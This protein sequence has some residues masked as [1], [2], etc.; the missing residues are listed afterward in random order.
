MSGAVKGNMTPC[1]VCGSTRFMATRCVVYNAEVSDDN[2]LEFLK[3]RDVIYEI[4]CRECDHTFERGP[5][6]RLTR[7][8]DD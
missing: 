2:F 5:D 8:F 3:E 4:S 6:E 7:D 1:D